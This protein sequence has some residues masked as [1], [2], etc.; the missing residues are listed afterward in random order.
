MTI[1]PLTQVTQELRASGS[2]SAMA[3]PAWSAWAL[4]VEALGEKCSKYLGKIWKNEDQLE[5]PRTKWSW[6]NHL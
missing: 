4:Q 6:E 5:T 2:G 3:E 1:H